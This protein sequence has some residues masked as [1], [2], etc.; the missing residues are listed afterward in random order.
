MLCFV[1]RSGM[2][3]KSHKRLYVKLSEIITEYFRYRLSICG[4]PQVISWI[5]PIAVI[6]QIY[7]V[8]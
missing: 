3:R 6:R 8:R 4:Q 1:A 5:G 2:L 7:Q